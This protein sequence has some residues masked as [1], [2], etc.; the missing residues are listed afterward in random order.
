MHN[1]IDQSDKGADR[2]NVKTR[3]RGLGLRD[4]AWMLPTLIL[5]VLALVAL[6]S[7]GRQVRLSRQKAEPA[8][9]VRGHLESAPAL[10]EQSLREVASPFGAHMVDVTGFEAGDLAIDPQTGGVFLVPVVGNRSTVAAS[11]SDI[12]V[13]RA[14]SGFK[15]DYSQARHQ[16]LLAVASK[17]STEV[18]YSGLKPS[19]VA[20]R[21]ATPFIASRYYDFNYRPA[22]GHHFVRGHFRSDGT[23]V[24]GHYKTNADDSF[25]NNWSSAGNVNAVTGKVGAKVPGVRTY[26]PSTTRR[27]TY[28]TGRTWVKGYRR[29]NG[30]YVRGHYR[31]R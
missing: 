25:W 7:C 10:L 1:N 2:H 17:E 23:F 13:F 8:L 27:P 14:P 3:S 26:T 21:R 6:P 18:T 19:T 22:V 5:T 29:K 12:S 4:T 30:T 28:S 24:A 20:S 16:Y 15:K 31:R 9:P 11:E